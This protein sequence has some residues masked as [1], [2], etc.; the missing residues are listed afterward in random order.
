MAAPIGPG[1][2]VECVDASPCSMYGPPPLT[3]GALYRVERIREFEPE[4]IDGWC[5]W[6]VG[7][8]A[9]SPEGAFG[10]GRFRPIYRPKSSIIEQLKQPVS[11]PIRDLIAAD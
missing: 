9:N 10:G 8:R 2:W 11:E 1:D 6:L 7:V 3:V 5:L 4:V